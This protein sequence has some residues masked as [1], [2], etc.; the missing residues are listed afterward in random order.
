MTDESGDLHAKLCRFLLQNRR[1]L[2]ISTGRS[3]GELMLRHNLRTRLDLLKSTYKVNEESHGKLRHFC[4]GDNVQVRDYRHPD[5][6]WKFGRVLSRT[7]DCHYEV[8]VNG[9]LLKRHVDQI[10]PSSYKTTDVQ[11]KLFPPVQ[12]ISNPHTLSTPHVESPTTEQSESQ[13]GN[14]S[15]HE[16]HRN[17]IPLDN[18]TILR[19]SSRTIKKPDRLN[20]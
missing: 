16:E 19:R 12:F 13:S 14:L 11:D 18:E 5:E 17:R 3:P 8:D 1:V 6:K 2:N 9:E 20:L 4:S 15:S 7:G 10:L